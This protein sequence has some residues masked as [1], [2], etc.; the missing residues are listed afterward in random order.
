MIVPPL[1][2]RIQQK[3]LSDHLAQ[4]IWVQL[5][6]FQQVHPSENYIK[7]TLE[8]FHESDSD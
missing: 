4:M 5:Y 7:T 2:P 8:K 6:D 3:L 1:S